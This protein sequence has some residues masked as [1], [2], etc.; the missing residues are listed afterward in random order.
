MT[1]QPI[2]RVMSNPTQSGRLTT[3]AIELSEFEINYAP[4]Q[5]L[6]HMSWPISLWRIVLDRPTKL[7]T[8]KKYP[9]KSQNGHYGEQFEYAL[10]FSFKITNNKVE[11]EAMVT[12]LQMAKA[13]D[14]TRLRVQGDSKLVIEQV[15][16]D[17]GVK[18]DT[19]RKY[20]AKA[21][22]LV[23][24]FEYVVFEYIPRTQNEHADH[25][26]L[27]ATTYFDEMPSH[28]KVE[29]KDAPSYEEG[30]S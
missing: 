12:G 7:R 27:L 14:I 5:R 29:V 9:M 8:R 15:R 3:W 20:H 21:T 25:L 2:K 26:S 16:G 10:H 17:C 23:Q 24:R 11:Y 4:T 22:L 1:D 6:R 28:V 13:L 19:L 18:S 30:R